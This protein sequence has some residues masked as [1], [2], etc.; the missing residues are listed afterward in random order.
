[1]KM[2]IS[3]WGFLTSLYRETYEGK[4][5]YWLLVVL[6][7][8]ERCC[9]IVRGDGGSNPQPGNAADRPVEC[10]QNNVAEYRR[11]G[12]GTRCGI[13]ASTETYH[14]NHHQTVSLSFLNPRILQKWVREI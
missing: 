14:G 2:K 11:Q 13:T 12:H 5:L 7:D 9:V 4:F 6:H 8:Q 10:Y 3:L 1:M